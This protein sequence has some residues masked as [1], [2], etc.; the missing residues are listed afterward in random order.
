MAAKRTADQL[1]DPKNDLWDLI[2]YYLRFQR[3]KRGLSGEAMGRI[4]QCGKS[5]V[6][7]IEIGVERLDGKQAE[8][9]D[10]AW[11]TGGL[12]A[13]LV[14]YA[15]LGHNP[16]WGA[17]YMDLEQRAG[18]LRVYEAQ[19]IAGL[20]QTE[21]YAR[22]LIDS[23]LA[24]QPEKVLQDRMTRQVILTREPGPYLSVILSQNALEWPVGS[25]AIMRAQLEAL[26]DAS[27]SHSVRVVPRQWS[28]AAHPGLDGS[29][30]L[31]S[32][33][34]FGEVAYTESPGGW[35][36]VSSPSDVMSYL[37]R[38]DRISVKALPEEP[39]RD[40]IRSAMEIFE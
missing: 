29:F 37:I 1:P 22:A 6:S 33:E 34:S 15:S 35:R 7:R 39:S 28:T 27:K 25:P 11:D 2:A 13:F 26:L 5:S 24:A 4:M 36:L 23:G 19:V 16:E 18:M 21:D 3:T 32:G 9:I 40:L 10:K 31:I 14:W 8:L 30:S 38:Y 20:L 12:F 17:Q